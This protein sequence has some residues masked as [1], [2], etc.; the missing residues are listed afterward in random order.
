VS[1]NSTITKTPI[2]T[3]QFG[4]DVFHFFLISQV[5][6]KQILI[7]WCGFEELY[8]RKKAQSDHLSSNSLEMVDI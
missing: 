5:P 7:N 6:D 3:E 8:R 4:N 2:K 1:F